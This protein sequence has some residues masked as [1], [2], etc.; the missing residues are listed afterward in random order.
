MAGFNLKRAETLAA[1][2][3]TAVVLA[4]LAVQAWH[5]GALWRDECDA[6]QLARMPGV[7]EMVTNAQYTSFPLL[8]PT[9]VRAYT[10]L[11]GTSDLALRV[12]GFF[13]GVALIGVAWF[14]SRT[15]RR[16][17]PLVLLALAGLN[18]VFLTTGTS[19]RGYGLG[20][21][22]IILAFTVTAKLI[23]EPSPQKLAASFAVYLAGMHCLYFNGALVPGILL[24]AF[25]VLLRRR[26]F[27]WAA[28]LAGVGLVCGLSYVPYLLRVFQGTKDYAMVLTAEPTA[29]SLGRQLLNAGGAPV[30]VMAFIWAGVIVFSLFGAWRWRA[31]KGA[32]K[33]GSERDLL[34]FAFLAMAGTS[35]ICFAFMWVLQNEPNAR[36]F[37]AL[38]CL[39]AAALDL[40]VSVLRDGRGVRVARMVCALGLAAVLPIF[41]WPEVTV[42][43]T[44]IDRLAQKLEE[45]AVPGDLI[46]VNPWSLGISF[47][48]YYQG[49]VRWITVPPL[50]EHRI[51]R[52]DLLKERMSA[53]FP[54]DELEREMRATLKSGH[55]IWIVGGMNVPPEGRRPM[56]LT[57]APDPEFGWSFSAYR[58][59]WSEQLG[60][61][62]RRHAVRMEL[63]ASK[64]PGVHE[65]ENIPLLLASE[66][67]P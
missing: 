45:A 2:F 6:L 66:W 26:R 1:L 41:L 52:Y 17:V 5:A 8:F 55:R 18:S 34:A 64:S 7:A 49:P 48:R 44:N 32:D 50:S 63:V 59:A 21:V 23:T 36:Y 61:F 28:L 13:V 37:L 56:M 9:I 31:G 16:D 62:M 10:A 3:L 54:L 15:L 60:S 27:K 53:F 20:G 14:H 12:F 42:R 46:V 22:L 25:V 30:P 24:A 19:I 51:N 43:Q 33:P 58:M 38:I 67:R 57:P 29:A 65:H 11:T 47:H 40:A 39:L 4:L 35:A